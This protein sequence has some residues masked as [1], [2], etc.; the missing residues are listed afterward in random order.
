MPRIEGWL[1]CFKVFPPKMLLME[2][3]FHHLETKVIQ[4]TVVYRP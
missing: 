4:I 3:I 1:K 2:E